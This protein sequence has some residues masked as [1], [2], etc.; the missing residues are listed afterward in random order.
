[1]AA[2]YGFAPSDFEREFRTGS[3]WF[4]I[5]GID[6]KRPRYPIFAERQAPLDRFSVGPPT[7]ACLVAALA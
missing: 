4:R 1:M 3:E 2:H 7:W 5:T 6:P